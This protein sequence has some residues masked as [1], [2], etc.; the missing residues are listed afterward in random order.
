MSDQTN[1]IHFSGYKNAWAVYMTI[2]NHQSTIL[3]RPE[4]I[5]I[6]LLGLLPIPPKLAES[7]KANKLQRLKN[8][9]SLC[10]VFKLILAR[11]K[12]GAPEGI[13]IDR[14]NSQ[15]RRYF[16]IMSGWIADHM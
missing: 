5:A 4:L 9:D 6:L 7:S 16:P 3:N 10:G 15:I 2:R 8:T 1:L 11:L 13:T 12:V 14:A